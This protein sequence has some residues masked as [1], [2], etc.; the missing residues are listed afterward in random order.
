MKIVFIRAQMDGERDEN[1]FHPISPSLRYKGD[2][3]ETRQ[4]WI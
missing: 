3:W 1:D 2:G 4:A